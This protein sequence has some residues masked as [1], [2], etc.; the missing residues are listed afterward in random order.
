[1]KIFKLIVSI[2]TMVLLLINP[3][4]ALDVGVSLLESLVNWL[5][6]IAISIVTIAIMWAGFKVIFRGTRI[7]EVAPIVIGG[8]LIGGAA[9]FASW[10]LG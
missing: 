3:V 9:Y 2:F 6:I 7:D 5:R 8:M 4:F 10:L 1:M